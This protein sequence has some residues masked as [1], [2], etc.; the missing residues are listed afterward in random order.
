MTRPVGGVKFVRIEFISSL[1][2]QLSLACAC[3]WRMGAVHGGPNQLVW[4]VGA[5]TA[6]VEPASRVLAR[7]VH[8]LGPRDV[9]ADVEHEA[10]RAFADTLGCAL[11]GVR[12][13]AS[14]IAAAL[15]RGERGHLEGT[16]V[17]AGPASLLPCVYANT[18]TA[19][20]LDFEPV[21]PEG[22][23]TLVA[24]PIALAVAEALGASGAELVS[25]LVAGI[26]VGGRIGA[27]VR[28]LD[29][30]DAPQLVAGNGHTVFAGAAVAG[31]L[32]GLGIEEL[33]HALGIAGYSAAVPT[34]HKF[35]NARVAPMTKYDHLPVTAQN[36]VQAALLAQRGFTGDP[37]V[38]DGDNGFWRFAGGNGYAPG[39][40]RDGLG[41]TWT[42]GQT[43]FK[44][45]P[46]NLYTQPAI[47][48]LRTLHA[49]RGF[50][51]ESVEAVEIRAARPG[52]LEL[53]AAADAPHEAWVSYAYTVAAGLCDILPRQS[54]FDPASYGD[55][56]LNELLRKIIIVPLKDE[57]LLNRGH[58]WEGWC[59]VDVKVVAG[60]QTCTASGTHLPELDDGS[61]RAKFLT[62]AGGVLDPLRTKNLFEASWGVKA[63]SNVRELTALLPVAAPAP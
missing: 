39:A 56:Q 34:L 58:Y 23:V 49:E 27:A 10:V 54:W 45:Y 13:T 41:E 43:Q 36:S 48:L 28:R 25:A 9:P 32:L 44:R 22:H 59:P 8:D 61:L 2:E 21:G 52:R 35:M 31:K 53:K 55:E 63:L 3:P 38:L 18:V 46:A 42:V 12:S 7:F 33:Q 20:A 26:E 1:Y 14:R 19:N 60:G 6:R 16:V 5:M 15:A 37:E 17:G 51:V 62:N 24:I 30:P 40:I 50:S 57:E 4:T 47:E 11:A 29:A